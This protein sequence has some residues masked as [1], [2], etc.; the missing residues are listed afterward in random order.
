MSV[1]LVDDPEST[2][3]DG[4][5]CQVP[6]GLLDISLA[7]EEAGITPEEFGEIFAAG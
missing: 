4:D 2:E 1:E 3:G 7:C 5:T 6:T